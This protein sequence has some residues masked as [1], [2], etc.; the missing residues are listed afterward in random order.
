MIPRILFYGGLACL[1]MAG[2]LLHGLQ[3]ALASAGAAML[4]AS[5]VETIVRNCD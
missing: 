2:G 4:A 1:V 3:P 5:L